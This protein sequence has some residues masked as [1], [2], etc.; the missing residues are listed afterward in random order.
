M[1]HRFNLSTLCLLVAVVAVLTSVFLQTYL[2]NAQ[3]WAMA[4]RQTAQIWAMTQ[5]HNAQLV[6]QAEQFKAQLA[7]EE[8]RHNAQLVAR[9]ADAR[10]VRSRGPE[11]TPASASER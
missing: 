3:L 10:K 6:A 11:E 4:Q 1:R 5:R 7:K 2:H 9:P 8:A